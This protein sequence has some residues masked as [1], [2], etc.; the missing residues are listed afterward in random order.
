VEHS[1]A[2][3]KEEQQAC[4]HNEERAATAARIGAIRTTRSVPTA[5]TQQSTAAHISAEHWNPPYSLTE[6]S[7]LMRVAS[8]T[9]VKP[10]RTEEMH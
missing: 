9:D 6:K 4:Q 5:A 7:T 3:T 8:F 2:P 1:Q 10:C